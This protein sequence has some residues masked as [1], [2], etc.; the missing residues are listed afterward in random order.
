MHATALGGRPP[1]HLTADLFDCRCPPGL[2][3]SGAWLA[4]LCRHVTLDAGLTLVGEHWRKAA[5]FQGAPGGV[6]GT[7]LLAESHLAVQTWP[8]RAGVTLD[9]HVCNA[10]QDN[11]HRAEA[12][13]S[14]LLA[15]FAPGRSSIPLQASP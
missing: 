15:A 10:T 1:L 6:R 14:A 3:S 12:L 13:V 7:L 9:V 2:L 11:K 5:P 4:D 8:E